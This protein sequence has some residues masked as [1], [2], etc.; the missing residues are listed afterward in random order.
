MAHLQQVQF[1]WYEHFWQVS[2]RIIGFFACNAQSIEN[3]VSRKV[4]INRL[5]FKPSNP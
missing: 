1:M 2:V 3:P 4:R 5:R